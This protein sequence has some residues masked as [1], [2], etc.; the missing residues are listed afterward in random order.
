[1]ID[2]T[3]ETIILSVCSILLC[4]CTSLFKQ[5]CCYCG[6][7]PKTNMPIC[8]LSRGRQTNNEGQALHGQSIDL[9]FI[10]ISSGLWDVRKDSLK[11]TTLLLTAFKVR[12]CVIFLL[13][14]RDRHSVDVC[15]LRTVSSDSSTHLCD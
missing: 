14:L 15:I 7:K 2:S 11:I 12:V 5:M 6:S 3:Q 4:P 8:E 13:L 1:M 10:A 9:D